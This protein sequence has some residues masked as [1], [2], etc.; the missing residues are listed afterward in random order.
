MNRKSIKET[1]A[2]KAEKIKKLIL[3]P[4]LSTNN[5]IIGNNTVEVI[6][7]MLIS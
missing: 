2:K 3:C 7:G 1:R 6:N 5:P 4:I